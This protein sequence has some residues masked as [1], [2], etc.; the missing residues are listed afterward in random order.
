M[1]CVL[2]MSELAYLERQSAL[3]ATRAGEPGEKITSESL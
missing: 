3:P 1:K 2:R